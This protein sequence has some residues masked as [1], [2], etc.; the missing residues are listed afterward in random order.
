MSDCAAERPY[1]WV[2]E[3]TL[4]IEDPQHRVLAS[5]PPPPSAVVFRHH[6]PHRARMVGPPAAC[7]TL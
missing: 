7:F 1:G 5:N 2:S 6:V 3:R 4:S